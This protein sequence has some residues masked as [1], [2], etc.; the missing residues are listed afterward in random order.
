MQL[1]VVAGEGEGQRDF[2]RGPENNEPGRKG[3]PPHGE[4]SQ[5]SKGRPFV[6]TN[7]SS[8]VLR[9]RPPSLTFISCKNHDAE[10]ASVDV[11]HS[12]DTQRDDETN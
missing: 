12:S 2:L 3:A 6:G 9:L 11:L 5:E 1:L 4:P 8:A 7:V 10:F